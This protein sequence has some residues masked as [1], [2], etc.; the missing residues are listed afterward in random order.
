VARG[1]RSNT[2]GTGRSRGGHR[3]ERRALARRISARMHF[4]VSRYRDIAG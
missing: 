2:S 4:G 1:Q 3:V